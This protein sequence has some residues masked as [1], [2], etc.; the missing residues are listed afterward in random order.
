MNHNLPNRI[1]LTVWAAFAMPF[2]QATETDG[3][4]ITAVQPSEGATVPLLSDFKKSYYA[5]PYAERRE[6]YGQ[7]AFQQQMSGNRHQ[8]LRVRL[9]WNGGTAPFSLKVARSDGS[10]F[11]SEPA[12]A[13]SVFDLRNLEIATTYH[14]TVTDAKGRSVSASFTT[15]A[16]APRMLEGGNVPNVRDLGGYV[17]L[18]GKRVRQGLVFRSAGLNENAYEPRTSEKETITGPRGTEMA[19]IIKAIDAECAA[20]APFRDQ[21][22]KLAFS[23][24]GLGHAWKCWTLKTAQ[25]E[26]DALA[27][28]AALSRGE[29]PTL[30]VTAAEAADDGNGVLRWGESGPGT[31]YLLQT[32]ASDREC[33]L[34]VKASADW[35]WALAV[36]GCVV[37]NHLGEGNGSAPSAPS[38]AMT[39]HLKPG[40]N[41]IAVA[42]TAGQQGWCW[43]HAPDPNAVPAAALGE[44]VRQLKRTRELVL[45]RSK[46]MH[47]GATRINAENR[48][49]WL[50]FLNIRTDIDLRSP[51]ECW[52]MTGSPL[53]ETVKWQH[54]SS[55]SYGDIFKPY[56][57]KAFTRVFR[58]FLDRENYPIDFHCIA[59]RDRTG[60]VAFVIGA[61]L[62]V[63]IDD[64]RKDWESTT[65]FGGPLNYADTF[66][67][68]E[69]GFDA[70]PGET[71]R[72]RVEAFVRELGFADA[73]FATLRSIMLQCD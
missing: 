21:P 47:A 73:D 2:V 6:K 55:A 17:A 10:Q 35:F 11:W 22:G 33:A 43:R 20:L 23:G 54:V 66:D 37:R 58:I 45:H 25:G 13:D 72:E 5:M 52:G 16:T 32:I 9:A 4:N 15:E 41:L 19:A 61:L 14:W 12:I 36:N 34:T 46:G 68:L 51:N 39:L 27:T 30:G 48:D 65:F 71:I 7:R 8:P 62:G 44:E 70:S 69:H 67:R 42:V 59:G 56:G 64:L 50:K 53:G 63:E 31:A 57:R 60:A 18:G 49:F 40:N 24:E 29:T 3:A 1:L 38:H 28:I 26:L